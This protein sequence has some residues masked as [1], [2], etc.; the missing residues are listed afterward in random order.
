MAAWYLAPFENNILE[1]VNGLHKDAVHG[2]VQ[3]V[4]PFI[5]E[6]PDIFKIPAIQQL[7]GQVSLIGSMLVPGIIMGAGIRQMVTHEGPAIGVIIIRGVVAA[8][9]MHGSIAFGL[10]KL[11]IHLSDT[12]TQAIFL[13]ESHLLASLTIL[14]PKVELQSFILTVTALVCWVYLIIRLAIIYITRILSIAYGVLLAPIMWALYIDPK[15][16]HFTAQWLK[17]LGSTIAQQFFLAFRLLIYSAI[18]FGLTQFHVG[19]SL[20]ELIADI[21]G[22]FFVINPPQFLQ[23]GSNGGDPLHIKALPSE[24]Q[25]LQK[26]TVKA[27]RWIN[28]IF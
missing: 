27:A 16:A 3:W 24:A 15:T 9:L 19:S 14:T 17:F 20:V 18:T 21:A 5:S 4:E 13:H 25:K 11:I 26:A 8:V 22:L 28:S 1:L 6:T 2:I 7:Y 23:F 10:A 12:L